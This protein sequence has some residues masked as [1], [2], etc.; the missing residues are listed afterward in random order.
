MRF[1]SR[2]ELDDAL[3]TLI[4]YTGWIASI[5]LLV[6][7]MLGHALEVAPG[8]PAATGMVLYKTV[9]NAANGN[10]DRKDE[11]D[12]RWSHLP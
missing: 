6:A 8:W 4:R 9:K 11:G 5:A 12:E 2:R 7:T 1:P 3:P 10:G